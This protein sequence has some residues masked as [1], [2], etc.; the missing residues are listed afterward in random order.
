MNAPF[1]AEKKQ[2]RRPGY[3]FPEELM[4][5]LLVFL[6]GII[7]GGEIILHILA[8]PYFKK[9]LSDHLLLFCP[10][11]LI[12]VD[13]ALKIFIMK[14]RCNNPVFKEFL[15]GIQLFS[16]RK[17]FVPGIFCPSAI[18]INDLSKEGE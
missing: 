11:K 5:D 17:E 18:E 8:I 7:P 1:F 15:T 9:N 16:S 13:L 2:F 10:R 3:K 6:K 4:N 14:N 12:V